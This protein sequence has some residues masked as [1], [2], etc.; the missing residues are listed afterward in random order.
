MKVKINISRQI[1]AFGEGKTKE[2]AIQSAL[3]SAGWDYFCSFDETEVTSCEPTNW[4]W[5]ENG[6]GKREIP[7]V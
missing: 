4:E 6:R 3:D 2:K 5:T 1:I 7:K